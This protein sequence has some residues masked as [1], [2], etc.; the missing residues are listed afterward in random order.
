MSAGCCHLVH[1]L[2]YA[3]ADE[4]RGGLE[5]GPDDGVGGA[6]EHKPQDIPDRSGN[7]VPMTGHAVYQVRG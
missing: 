1:V 5:L 2:I 6:C 4:R 7:L 3:V